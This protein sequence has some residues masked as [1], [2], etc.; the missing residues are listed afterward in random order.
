[1]LMSHLTKSVRLFKAKAIK[2]PLHHTARVW[3]VTSGSQLERVFVCVCVAVCV[4][5]CSVCVCV[6]CVCVCF[7]VCVCVYTYVCVCAGPL[8]LT[9]S[10]G[11]RCVCVTSR[12]DLI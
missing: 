12:S 3:V 5:V 2:M 7:S 8:R 10:C 9:M 6:V 11:P 1:M 4:C